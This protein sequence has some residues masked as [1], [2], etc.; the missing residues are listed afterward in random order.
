MFVCSS[1]LSYSRQSQ[2]RYVGEPQYGSM[3]ACLQY[4]NYHAYQVICEHRADNKHK[5][6]EKRLNGLPLICS[7]QTWVYR[8]FVMVLDL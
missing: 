3:F 5:K 7:K 8:Q 1:A 2:N 4:P 6:R